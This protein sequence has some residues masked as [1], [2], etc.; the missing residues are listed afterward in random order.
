MNS[1]TF[2]H[3]GRVIR[4]GI[5]G[6]VGLALTA[7]GLPGPHHDQQT[8]YR[9]NPI[10]AIKQAD[11]ARLR[12]NPIVLRLDRVTAANGFQSA[13]MMYSRDRQTLARYRDNR[14][15][16]PPA[17]L[18]GDAMELSLLHQPWVAGVLRGGHRMSAL[19]DIQCGLDRLEHDVLA[20]GGR[21]HL[22]MTC[23]LLA[24]DSGKSL[25]HWRF[26]RSMPIKRNDAEH[27]ADAAQALLDQALKDLVR[28]VYRQ[29]KRHADS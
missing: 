27:Y 10:P 9:L 8:T 25:A 6:L 3:T 21:V 26:D 13:A 18:I 17:V 1:R 28:R 20:K 15:I 12:S 5:V 14:W 4:F 29:A 23:M 19:M 24:D 11:D 2:T 7:C 22:S 16:A